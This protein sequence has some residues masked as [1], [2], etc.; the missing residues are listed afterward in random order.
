YK[1]KTLWKEDFEK[2]LK[3]WSQSEIHSDVEPGHGFPWKAVANAPKHASKAAYG[4]DP[5]GGSCAGDAD[6]YTSANLLKSKAIKLTGGKFRRLSFQHYV[7]TE[8]GYDGGNV[9]I[10]VNGKAFKVIPTAAYLFNGPNATLTTLA[11]GGTNPLNG[12]EGFTGTNGGS[13]FG[14]WGTSIVDLKK[15]GAHVGDKI[16]LRFDMGRDGCGG[17]DGW[18]VDN[19]KVQVC[20]KKKHHNKAVAGDNRTTVKHG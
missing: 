16:K 9:K 6:D 14:S 2:G 1:T 12:Q 3:N 13:V 10:S 17:I 11:E 15:A 4:P 5:D 19:I 20:Q 18:Y 8:A 7:A